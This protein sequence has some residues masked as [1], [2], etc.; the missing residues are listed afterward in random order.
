MGGEKDKGL[1]RRQFIK[2]AATSAIVGAGCL[3][4]GLREALAQAKAAGKPLFTT[5]HVNALI[6]KHQ[7]F[8]KHAN[9]AKLDLKGWVRK[10]F[11]LAPEQE[12]VLGG[13]TAEKVKRVKDAIRLAQQKNYR[14]LVLI[15]QPKPAPAANLRLNERVPVMGFLAPPVAGLAAGTTAGDISIDIDASASKGP[16]GWDW[17]GTVKVSVSY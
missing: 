17:E 3:K 15:G 13:L 5:E 10:N 9:E 4:F 12:K 14:F 11:Y 1:D 2:R 16:D 7:D 6:A 8:H